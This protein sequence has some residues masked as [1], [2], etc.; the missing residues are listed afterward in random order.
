MLIYVYLLLRIKFNIL[1]AGKQIIYRLLKNFYYN[2]NTK[3]GK[4]SEVKQ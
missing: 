4:I 2:Q 1:L 3:F